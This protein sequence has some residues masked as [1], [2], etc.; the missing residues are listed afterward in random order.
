M[1]D[2]AGTIQFERRALRIQGTGATVGG[3]SSTNVIAFTSAAAQFQTTREGVPG[4]FT[5]PI[6]TT[7]T[8]PAE[9]SGT[10][11]NA[12]ISPT[13]GT[14][15]K[16]C[17][18]GVYFVNLAADGTAGDTAGAQLAITLDQGVALDTVAAGTVTALSDIVLDYYTTDG[19]A[20]ASIP[21][22]CGVPVYITDR[23][24]NG[25]QPT[26]DGVTRGVGVLRMLANNGANAV[27]ATAFVVASIRAT[28]VA[29]NEISGN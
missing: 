12:V 13:I 11:I 17:R 14:G 15:F 27:V 16:F 1:A 2:N 3:S 10:W 19:V 23:L 29:I 9:N 26:A 20:A 8:A 7:Y 5:Y 4:T 6:G 25:A 18:K 21:A 22:R 24:A 28:I